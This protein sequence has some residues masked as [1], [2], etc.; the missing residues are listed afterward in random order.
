MKRIRPWWPAVVLGLTLAFGCNNADDTTDKDDETEEEEQEDLRSTA[1][2]KGPTDSVP[3]EHALIE[4][5]ED[6]RIEWRVEPSGRLRAQVFD[7]EGKLVAPSDVTGLVTVQGRPAKLEEDGQT[8]QANIGE[9][10]Q[11]LTDVSYKL[12]VGDALW[13]GVLQLPPGGTEP[14]LVSPPATVEVGA[15]GPNGG[16]VDVVGDQ[17]VEILIDEDSGEVRV[18]FLD[19]KLQP[20]P[21][22]DAEMTVGFVE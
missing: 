1:K 2:G 12:A 3:G 4:Q 13:E 8:L 14:L 7:K 21:V 17:R 20:M 16:V 10:S 15:R 6:G 18:Y 9:L 5:R 22:G 11:D 19:E